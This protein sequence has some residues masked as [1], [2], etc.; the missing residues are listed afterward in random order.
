MLDQGRRTLMKLPRR[1]FLH[2]AA[3]AAVLPAVSRAAWAQAYPS[4]PVRIIAPTGPAGAPDI[5][6]RLIAPWLSERLGQQFVVENRPGSGNNIGTEAVVRAPPDGYTLLIVSSSNTINATLYDKLNFVF[7]RDIAPVA[8]LIS[9]PF[10]M[11]VNPWVPAKTVAELAAYAKANPGKISFGS[12][13]IG[14]PGHVAGELFKIMAGVDMVHVPYRGGGAV[15][16]DLLGGQVQVFF[17]TTSLTVQQVTAGKLRAL[18]VTSASRWEGLPDVPTVGDFVPGYEA[19]SLF[20]VGAPKATPV[21]IIDRLNREINA[22][23]EDPKLKTRL[24]ELGGTLLPGSPADF[25]KLVADD[26]EKWAKVIRAVN[27]KAE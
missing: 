21:G 3:G 16:S 15:M 4:R 10:V 26:T 5:L 20:G 17:G 2:L 18:A 23:L 12:P 1:Q 8:G 7:L 9:L 27:I 11:V 22:A 25:G 6:A 24:L 19:T 13:G 14:T